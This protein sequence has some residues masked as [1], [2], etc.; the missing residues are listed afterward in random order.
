[1]IVAVILLCCL[2]WFAQWDGYGC[3]ECNYDPYDDPYD[4]YNPYFDD[5]EEDL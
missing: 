5:D 3:D 2:F 4:I 1:M